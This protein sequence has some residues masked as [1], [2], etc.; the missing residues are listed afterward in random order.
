[1]KEPWAVKT[2]DRSEP[3]INEEFAAFAEHYGCAVYPARVR[4][5]KDKALVENA[6]KLLYR[7]VYLD[8]EGMVFNS[9]DG[10][11]TAIHISLLDFNEKPMAGRELSR[12]DIFLRGEKDF[13]RPL[14][15]KLFVMKE[16]KL[17]T[18][19]KTATYPCSGT[20]TAFPANMWASVWSSST[21]PTQWRYIAV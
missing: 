8:I 15:E 4:H 20:T 7:S 5:P 17:M 21:M 14:S 2:S 18:V 10:L 12:R 19:G 3:V 9:L 1:M 11:N 16:R 13:L 6:V